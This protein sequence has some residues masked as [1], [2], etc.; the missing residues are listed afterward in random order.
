MRAPQKPAPSRSRGAGP[1]AAGSTRGASPPRRGTKRAPRRVRKRTSRLGRRGID[2]AVEVR[3][4]PI[5]GKGVFALET[6]PRDTL[7]GR[8]LGTP[9][10]RNGVYVLWI[11]EDD[12]VQC[13]ISGENDLRYVNHAR[14]P[15]AIFLGDE[16]VALRRIRAGEEITFNYGPEAPDIDLED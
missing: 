12:D 16:L 10:K 7:I 3:E 1:G 15:N 2:C 8:Y 6:I 14:R 11:W 5:H 4:S 13:P 9:A